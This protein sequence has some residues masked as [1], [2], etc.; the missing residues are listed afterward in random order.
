MNCPE[1]E[2]PGHFMTRSTNI[3]IISLNSNSKSFV[4]GLEKVAALPTVAQPLVVSYRLFVVVNRH[5]GS[6][7]IGNTSMPPLSMR[8][9]MRDGSVARCLWRRIRIRCRAL[10]SS[11]PYRKPTGQRDYGKQRAN[12]G[13]E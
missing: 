2:R 9:E 10:F 3:S 4:P 12:G 13:G 8:A 11:V 7:W 5:E 1:T 6:V